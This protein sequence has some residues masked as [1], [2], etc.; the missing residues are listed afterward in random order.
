MF[1]GENH[2]G[3]ILIVRFASAAPKEKKIIK[4]T[5][6]KLIKHKEIEAI[7]VVEPVNSDQAK[8]LGRDVN[9]FFLF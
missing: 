3:D 5:K 7:R 4:G 8:K 1:F 2:S 6:Q 9:F